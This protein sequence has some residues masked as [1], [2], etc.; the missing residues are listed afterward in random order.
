MNWLFFLGR[1]LLVAIFYSSA[2]S[3]ITNFDMFVGIAGDAGMPFPVIAIIGAIALDLV[4]ATL[5]LVG[6]KFA[7]SGAALL[8]LFLIVATPF[9]HNFWVEAPGS[10]AYTNQYNNFMKNVSIL[11]AMFIMLWYYQNECPVLKFL[12]LAK[13]E[14]K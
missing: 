13:G 14:K 11:G 6:K 4:G 5:L 7:G 12:G 1:L 10:L 9:F 3:K 8:I 2:Y